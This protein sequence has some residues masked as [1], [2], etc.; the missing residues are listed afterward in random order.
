MVIFG[1]TGDLRH[2]LVV[3]A[4]YNLSLANR[5]PN[6][7]ALIGVARAAGSTESWRNQL[8]APRG[9][10]SAKFHRGLAND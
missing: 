9:R 10:V 3:P 1:A 4:L 8:Y 7:F 2:R 5:Q 6:R